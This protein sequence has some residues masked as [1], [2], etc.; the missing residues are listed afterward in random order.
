MAGFGI[1]GFM[2]GVSEFR[3]WVRA[4]RFSDFEKAQGSEASF[5]AACLCGDDPAEEV[6]TDSWNSKL[7]S[8]ALLSGTAHARKR[9]Y[10]GEMGRGR[11]D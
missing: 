1:E 10:R 8:R 4:Q 11:E 7:L 9:R 3:V 6:A 5:P 2:G